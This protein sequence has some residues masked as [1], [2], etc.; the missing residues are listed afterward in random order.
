MRLTDTDR[1]LPGFLRSVQAGEETC[2]PLLPMRPARLPGLRG[3][4]FLTRVDR[5]DAFA[6]C[7]AR[8]GSPDERQG[9]RLARGRGLRSVNPPV[10][11][12]SYMQTARRLR[13]ASMRV[14][15]TA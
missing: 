2:I 12:A 1:A 8:S 5:A 14:G 4:F 6:V 10:Q 13:L 9:V 3:A 15:K 7:L 11:L